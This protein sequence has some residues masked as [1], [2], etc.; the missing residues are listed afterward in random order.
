MAAAVGASAARSKN[1][2][3][4]DLQAHA[5]E[6]I[7]RA[8]DSGGQRGGGKGDVEAHQG[9]WRADVRASF[10]SGRFRQDARKSEASDATELNKFPGISLAVSYENWLVCICHAVCEAAVAP[11]ASRLRN[12]PSDQSGPETNTCTT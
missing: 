6:G 5:G 10:P 7:R 12:P 3:A 2:W 1:T 11:G 4:R 8:D 9:A